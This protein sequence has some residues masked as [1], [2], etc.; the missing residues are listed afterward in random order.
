MCSASDVTGSGRCH[1]LG[2]IS[3]EKRSQG[4]CRD[5]TET[6][7]NLLPLMR[8]YVCVCLLESKSSVSR[9]VVM[10]LKCIRVKSGRRAR[11]AA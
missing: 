8:S 10:C 7:Q 1:G 4:G 3:G 2:R 11:T 9:N 6:P 5:S